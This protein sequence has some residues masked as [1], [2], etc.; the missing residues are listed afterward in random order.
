[1]SFLCYLFAVWLRPFIRYIIT[2]KHYTH[3]VCLF[4]LF[5][6]VLPVALVGQSLTPTG[7]KI[8]GSLDGWELYT[9]KYVPNKYS[10]N[11]GDVAYDYGY[12]WTSVTEA[13]ARKDGRIL[14]S[15]DIGAVDPIIACSG[16][17]VNPDNE[18]VIQ[19]G[20]NSGKAEAVNDRNA[21]YAYA[22]RIKY[23]FDVTE[24][25]TLFT[26]KYAC[27]LHVPDNDSHTSYMM[28]AFLV[29]VLLESPTGQKITLPCESFSGN[30][31]FNNSMKRNLSTCRESKVESGQNPEDYVYQPWTT[32]SY[33]LTSYIGYK[34][35]IEII[36]HDCLVENKYGSDNLGGGSHKAYGYFWG[37]TEPLK[38]TPKNCG[39][40][41]AIIVAPTG[42]VNYN[43]Y[44]CDESGILLKSDGNKI[45]IPVDEIVDGAHY[46]CE[47]VGSNDACTKITTDT[48]LSTIDLLADFD[49][50]NDCDM[51]VNFTDK[52]KAERDTIQ[53]YRWDFGDGYSSTSPSPTHEYL[54]S[55]SYDVSLTIISGNGCSNTIT[56]PVSVRPLPI[57]TIDGDQN[58]CEGD[59]IALSCLS[60]QV[61][62]SFFW[63]NQKG[64]TVSRDISLQE[65]A[66]VSQ[67]Y[68][69]YI[70]DE[71][72]CSYNKTV[73][74]SVSAAPTVFIKGD[75][76]VCFNTP[77]KLWVW[78]D[79]DEYVWSTA[80]VGDTLKLTPQQSSTYCV[81][82]EYTQTGC[83][84]SKCVSL[85]INPLP[86][87]KIEGASSICSG[88]QT[89]LYAVGAK[90]YLWQDVYYGDSMMISPT[91]TTIYTILGTDSNGCSNNYEHKLVV[92][93]S[94]ALVLHGN[95][96][97]CEGEALTLWLEGAQSYLWDDGVTKSMVT[98]T[99]TLN[100]T[101]YKVQGSTN[102]CVTDT[103]IP[104][105]VNPVPTI[106]VQGQ[107]EVCEGE[108][109]TLMV[110][111]GDTYKW[112]TGETTATIEKTL[113]TS[114][115]F[116]VTGYS[117]KNC[118]GTA[119]F[120]VT[121][122]PQPK[123][124]IQ[125]P[126]SVCEGETVQLSAFNENDDCTYQWDNGYLGKSYVMAISDTTTFE[127]MATDTATGCS[128]IKKHTVSTLPFPEVKV[129]GKT[130]VCN[131]ITMQ[132][133]AS[134]AASY[135]WSDSSTSNMLI[136]KATV[137]TV[138]WVEGTTNGCTTRKEVPITVLPAPYVWVDGITTICFG[139]TLYLTARG[140]ESYQW[141]A[142]VDGQNYKSKPNVSSYVSLIGTG[143][144]GC[145]TK[146]SIPFTVRSKPTVGISGFETICK[147]GTVSLSATGRGLVQ[148]AW[149]TG[150]S[151]QS[152]EATLPET[153]TFEVQ[154]WDTLGCTN[155]AQYTVYT[156]DPPVISFTGDTV[157]CDGETITLDGHGA[158]NFS[159]IANGSIVGQGS[160]LSYVPKR[161]IVVQMVGVQ[162]NCSS[163]KD[164]YI[165]VNQIPNVAIVGPTGVCKNELVDLTATGAD[166]YEW[167]TGDTTATINYPISVT[168]SYIVNGITKS[169]CN[170]KKSVR[171]EVYPD[172]SVS[173]E[174]I[175]KSGCP[176]A[177]TTVVLGAEG[178]L[179][180]TYS[181]EPYN[182]TIS[183]TT[184]YDLE[185]LIDEPTEVYVIGTDINGCKGYD[186]ISIEPKTSEGMRF[187]IVPSIVEESNP[188]VHLTGV[189]PIEAEWSW[190]LKALS[191]PHEVAELDGMFVRYEFDKEELAIEDSFKVVVKVKDEN[192]CQ[193]SRSSYVYV[194]KD[195]WAPTAFSPNGDGMNDVFRF[196]G[197]DF[198]EDFHYVIYN[199]HGKIVFKGDS[200]KDGWDGTY[201]N[202]EE[203]PMGVYG[204]SVSYKSNYKGIDKSGEY[205]GFV[206]V[207]R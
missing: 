146:L 172:L 171:V 129:D 32:V 37:K 130:T 67:T 121:V 177:P 52:S 56:K 157:V 147:D 48:V 35:T 63:L 90:E 113:A 185:A 191:E 155:T 12:E 25:S 5:M 27:V 135:L 86:D 97:V 46:C 166:R 84:A 187:N 117:D 22:E 13:D 59:M 103:V 36:N 94:P 17:Y 151:A 149:S 144:N 141:N 26:Y 28:P 62:S 85:K 64:D 89:T 127:V 55:G 145:T 53:K 159:W 178:A 6:L 83:K 69:V 112:A 8:G 156:I 167:S 201:S 158:T 153:K 20:K 199:R 173:L 43:W 179:N 205:K 137:N 204:W 197:G 72:S 96:E 116:Y 49:Y 24:E 207:I 176:D 7:L 95:K 194:W 186:T 108:N 120:P 33:D 65:K 30:A 14:L 74:V 165:K 73:N 184:S 80:Y 164:I 87:V 81:T 183:G 41:D 100:T 128:S 101:S 92:N 79:A 168:T 122:H 61:G 124:S 160:R 161:N 106:F 105:V 99:P 75:S 139:D 18:I 60:S 196:K 140:A 77:A 203:C 118:V 136:Q 206:S 138:M 54:S 115:T 66:T 195:V 93:N 119:S 10:D 82:G 202:G 175:S 31:S 57:L 200:V 91:E 88:S 133:A 98:R 143:E 180:Y 152:I 45:T 193:Y 9:G 134:G 71:Y 76:S 190:R 126:T 21:L 4:V 110:Q 142:S 15:S 123:F 39:N 114:Q 58:V 29:S 70:I 192:G 102:G 11:D 109:I 181:S 3:E 78:G 132:L 131:G 40:D 111:G 148:F 198:I 162:N 189:N 50:E 2:M 44:R 16:F 170:A 154:A 19:I 34:V 47:M 163:T 38:L 188:I 169:G 42:F 125:G 68:S 150:E 23:S 1:M 51:K 104:I 182:A 107:E 174:E